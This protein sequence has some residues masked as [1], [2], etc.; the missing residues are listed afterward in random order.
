MHCDFP[1]AFFML[2]FHFVFLSRKQH[3]LIQDSMNRKELKGVH[4]SVPRY[5]EL[6]GGLHPKP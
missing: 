3:M 6:G 1:N 5:L 2:G 4:I